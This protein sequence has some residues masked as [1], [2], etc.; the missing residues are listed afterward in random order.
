MA[1]NRRTRGRGAP[2][3]SLLMTKKMREDTPRDLEETPIRRLHECLYHDGTLMSI[4]R[5][6]A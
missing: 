3:S 6:A 1:I 2:V 5:M 4:A